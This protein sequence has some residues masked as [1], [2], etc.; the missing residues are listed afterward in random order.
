MKPRVLEYSKV[1]NL[2]MFLKKLAER[3]FDVE[4]G[5]HLVLEDHS[6]LGFYRISKNAKLVAY[7]IAHYLTQYYKAVLSSENKNDK[8]FLRELLEIKYSGERWSIPIDSI[9]VV[10]YS[11]EIL[12]LLDK[13]ED[14]YPVQNAEEILQIYRSRNPNYKLIPRIVVARLASE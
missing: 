8:E 10:L 6:E 12:E 9:Y 13:Y 7:I 11:E 3:G 2:D 14:E 4:L 5:P 1:K